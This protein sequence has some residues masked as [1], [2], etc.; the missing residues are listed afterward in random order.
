MST[1]YLA[2]DKKITRYAKIQEKHS[3]KR[4]SKQWNHT[5]IWQT[6]DLK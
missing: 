4:Q 5:D 6:W 3:Q 2:F 1:L